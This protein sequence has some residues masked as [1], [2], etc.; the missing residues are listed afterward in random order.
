MGFALVHT[1]GFALVTARSLAL[2]CMTPGLLVLASSNQG[3]QASG[4]H[5]SNQRH[6]RIRQILVGPRV[7][8]RA[9]PLLLA[10]FLQAPCQTCCSV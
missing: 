7:A 1:L 8:Y 2:S 3:G 4:L 9:E 6:R 10:A 5:T